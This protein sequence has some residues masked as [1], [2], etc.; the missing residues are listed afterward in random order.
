[1][2]S[3]WKKIRY[4]FEYAIAYVFWCIF[5]ALPIDWASY[6][7]G[8][9]VSML[10]RILPSQ[11]TAM[12][13]LQRCLPGRSAEEYKLIIAK[14]WDNLG[15][16]VGE[17][18]HW[19]NMSSAEFQKRVQLAFPDANA[20]I[21]QKLRGG[22][23]VSAHLG[24]WEIYCKFSESY[25]VNFNLLYRPAN[26]PY[27]DALINQQRLRGGVVLIKKGTSGLRQVMA[28]LRQEK[29]VGMLVD[30]RTDEGI[31]VP[32]F[33]MLAKTTAAPANIALKYGTPLVMSRVVRTHGANYKLE[34]YEPLHVSDADDAQAVMLKIHK[35]F[36]SW[37]LEHPEQWFWVHN[38][39]GK[40][41]EQENKQ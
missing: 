27:I 4:Q 25:Q 5:S 2:I 9:L 3:I 24:N 37:I 10:G 28:S 15:R 35:Y 34:F 39:W 23:C 40:F 12:R 16:I 19:G 14:M 30:Q 38:R 29:C 26:N 18:P 13:N 31:E 17:L 41:Y 36:E 20:D 33:G 6:V 22:I 21:L 8:R 11:R 32:F 7:G 1:M